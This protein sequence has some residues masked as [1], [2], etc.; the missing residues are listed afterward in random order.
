MIGLPSELYPVIFPHT[1][2][3]DIEGF[4]VPCA[5]TDTTI[6][7]DRKKNSAIRSGNAR[8]VVEKYF[9]LNITDGYRGQ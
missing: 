3:P 5:Y 7:G 4:D 6:T 1:S 9:I 8:S 2:S